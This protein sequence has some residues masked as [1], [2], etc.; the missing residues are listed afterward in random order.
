MSFG[1]PGVL[2]AAGTS[3]QPIP[4]SLPAPLT[5]NNP[6]KMA[7]PVAL[8][9]GTQ[10][11]LSYTV[12]NDGKEHLIVVS[13]SLVVSS[14]ETGGACQ[15]TFTQSGNAVTAPLVTAGQA[16][17]TG[18]SAVRAVDPGSTVSITQSS[19]LSAGAATL[20]GQIYDLGSV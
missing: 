17:S 14:A 6:Q 16:A 11:F 18:G 1:Q 7:A 12:P 8:I 5:P 2:L 3:V 20:Q 13:A 9:N 10:T 19:A 15:A 4:A